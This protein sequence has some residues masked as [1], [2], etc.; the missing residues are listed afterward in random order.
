MTAGAVS[1]PLIIPIIPPQ[2]QKAKNH[3]STNTP[4][5]IQSDTV[6]VL[7]LYTLDGSMPAAVQRG[8]ASRTRKY[9]K[10]IL[11]PTGR[12][13]VRAVAVTSDGRQSSTVTKVFT[14]E[15]VD[16]NSNEENTLQTDQQ[17]LSE[18]ATE[19]ST[20]SS[21][22][23]P[24]PVVIGKSSPQSGIHFLNLSQQDSQ[25]TANR[26]GT[27]QYSQSPEH[28]VCAC[29]GYG[30]PALISSCLTC[31][32]HLQPTARATNSIPSVL[33]ADSK[34]KV[35]ACCRCKRLNCSDARYCDWCGLKQNHAASVICWRCGAS[36]FSN[37]AYCAA[38]G[39][40]LEA[41]APST[42][43]NN[44]VRKATPPVASLSNPICGVGLTTPTVEKCTQTVGVYD[45]SVT[46]LQKEEQKELRLNRQQVTRDRQPPLC[47]ISPGRGYWRKQLDHVCA[48]L[49]SYA[50]NNTPFRALLGEPRLGRMVSAVIQ[51]DHFEFRVTISF[52]LA[53]G[54]GNLVD[55]TGLI[56]SPT[57]TLS[58]V[59]ERSEDSGS[60]RAEP[61]GRVIHVAS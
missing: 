13:P 5:S 44:T 25:A 58:S 19:N 28:V 42:Y 31:E 43:C 46:K 24:G 30:N 2:I 16:S 50:Q 27:F 7:I 8:A 52:V 36:G 59:T 21:L 61:M 47:A 14:V 48:H 57:E 1:T 9:R 45:K 6:G 56:A 12:V 37:A 41:P 15:F 3:I 18:G 60:F 35:L 54:K 10:P 23:S 51:Q 39:V 26:S 49:R 34:N 4:V 40:F 11:L 53:G 33:S 17:H 20:G 29:C 38:C 55:P 22:K 32:N